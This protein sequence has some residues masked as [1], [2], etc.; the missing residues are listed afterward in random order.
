MSDQPYQ[1]QD[2]RAYD[3]DDPELGV[4]KTDAGEKHWE[5]W[6]NRYRKCIALA[7]RTGGAW[8]DVACGSGYGT[9]MIAQ[10]AD[11]AV[12]VDLDTTT[13]AYARKHHARPNL[14]Y[15][16]GSILDLAAFRGRR[17]DAIVSIETIEHVADPT[18]FFASVRQLL[19]PDG[20]FVV[21]TPESQTGGG[22]NPL[23]RWHLHEFTREQLVAALRGH[24]AEVRLE[25]EMA[26]FTTGVETAQLYAVCRGPLD[27]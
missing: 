21:T 7:G 10:A 24:F 9:E 18:P 25:I 19:K 23:N 27:P 17:F 6:R 26:I 14:T 3:M 8:M 15:H 4:V 22:P 2:E 1:H 5:R 12:G 16:N 13:I 20:V 11:E